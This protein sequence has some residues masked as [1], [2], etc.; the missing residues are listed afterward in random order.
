MAGYVRHCGRC[1]AEVYTS[2]PP[3]VRAGSFEG[4]MKEGFWVQGLGFGISAQD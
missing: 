4:P 1:I 3:W 2:Q